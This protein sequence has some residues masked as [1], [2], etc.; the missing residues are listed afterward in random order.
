M[1]SKA[2]ILITGANGYIGNCLFH[3]LKKKFNVIGVDCKNNIN[4]D[5][6]KIN[7]LNIKKL[8][9]L[10][11]QIK[12]KVVIHLAAQSLVDETINKKKYY[13]NNVLVTKHLIN[14]MKKNNIQNIIFSSTASVYKKNKKPLSEKSKLEPLSYYAKTKFLCENEIKFTR[15]LNSIILR[16]FNV[17]S[18]LSN[19]LVGELHNPETHLIPTTVYKS[20]KRKKIYIYGKNFDTFDGTC[21]RDYIHIKDICSAIDKSIKYLIQ[22]KNSLLLNIGNSR[23]YSNKEILN[24]VKKKTKQPIKVSFIKKKTGDV[25]SLLCNYKKAKSFL[26]WKPIN[27]K[28]DKIIKDEIIWIKKIDKMGIKRKF[29]N[30]IK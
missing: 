27:S 20:L 9:K 28:L 6:Y 23:G 15:G 14:L 12:P 30:Y 11:S 19:P 8:D 22:N 16:F 3:F 17:C 24:F 18:A 26:S 5:I 1:V 29:K 2:K 4:G 21:V 7:L 25:P 13:K 10:L